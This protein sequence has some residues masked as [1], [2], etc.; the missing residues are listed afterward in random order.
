M[1]F[2]IFDKIRNGANKVFEKVR[3]HAPKMLEKVS[4]GL[5]QAG[6]IAKH[7]EGIGQSIVNNPIIQSGA[8]NSKYFKTAQTALNSNLGSKLLHKSSDLTNIK[9]YGG[10]SKDIT[11]N[12]LER[13]KSIGRDVQDVSGQ[14][15]HFV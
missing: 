13:A 9:N 1:V 11:N 7:I 5:S 8:G 6:N 15:M 4:Q 2:K 12:I 3:T 14:K 10:D